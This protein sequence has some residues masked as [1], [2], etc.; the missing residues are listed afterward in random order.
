MNKILLMIG[1]IIN[2]LLGVFHILLGIS[3]N[4]ST[5]LTDSDKALMQVFNIGSILMVFFFA[6]VSIVFVQE[7]HSSKLGKS[8]IIF[9][10]LFYFI[11]AVEEPIFFNFSLPIFG[12]CIVVGII[13]LASLFIPTGNKRL[14]TK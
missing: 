4:H 7:L 12:L 9:I 13:Y 14:I 10:S 11:R 3:I 8:I 2:V 6:S 5:S 1:G